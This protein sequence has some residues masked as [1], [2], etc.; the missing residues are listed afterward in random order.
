MAGSIV[1]PL[2]GLLLLS[3]LGDVEL[4]ASRFMQTAVLLSLARTCVTSKTARLASSFNGMTFQVSTISSLIVLAAC[5]SARF[6]PIHSKRGL[7]FQGNCGGSR[8]RTKSCKCTAT[9]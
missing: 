8:E 4:V 1:V 6:A 9:L 7:V 3:F 2:L 5:T